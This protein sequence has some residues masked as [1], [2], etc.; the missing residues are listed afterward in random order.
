MHIPPNLC[1]PIDKSA[2]VTFRKK[3]SQQNCVARMETRRRNLPSWK[4]SN[5]LG[6]DWKRRTDF[7]GALHWGTACSETFSPPGKTVR[8]S[9][10]EPEH[11]A[12]GLAYRETAV[13]GRGT[14]RRQVQGREGKSVGMRLPSTAAWRKHLYSWVL[15]VPSSSSK[16]KGKRAGDA[17]GD[18]EIQVLSVP[19]KSLLQ[20]VSS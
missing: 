3:W 2:A 8:R 7:D 6:A 18:W 9:L 15:R 19:E 20:K 12:L 5:T 16:G 11:T 10:R 17:L 4:G 1:R 13:G 14:G